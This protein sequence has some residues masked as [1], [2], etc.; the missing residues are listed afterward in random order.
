MSLFGTCNINNNKSKILDNALLEYAVIP[1]ILNGFEQ[2]KSNVFISLLDK[3][4]KELSITFGMF[5]LIQILSNF[6]RPLSRAI[7]FLMLSPEWKEN[8]IL[9]SAP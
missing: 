8:Y 7:T 6:K 1:G 4:K 9:N 5:M 2:K 3:I